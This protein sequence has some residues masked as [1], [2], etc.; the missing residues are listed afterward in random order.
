MT[1]RVA[2]ILIMVLAGG[3]G[4][5]PSPDADDTY[6]LAQYRLATSLPASSHGQTGREWSIDT[7]D[8]F[9]DKPDVRVSVRGRADEPVTIRFSDEP[10][11]RIIDADSG[12]GNVVDIRVNHSTLFV[13]WE[14]SQAGPSYHLVAYGLRDRK[15]L[16]RWRVNPADAP[17]IRNQAG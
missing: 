5:G 15:V 2:L 17:M 14:G 16:A 3:S 4:C 13:C 6:W 10:A 9:W 1:H 12:A 11:H 8:L 7:A